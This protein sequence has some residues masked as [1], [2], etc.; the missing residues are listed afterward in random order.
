LYAAVYEEASETIQQTNVSK[1]G[2]LTF[3]KLKRLYSYWNLC[4]YGAR[5][6]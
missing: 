4:S 3:Q 1:A 5:I 6:M 2:R